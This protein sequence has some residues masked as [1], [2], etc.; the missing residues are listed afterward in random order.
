MLPSA[1][2]FREGKK[3]RANIIFLAHWGNIDVFMA[4]TKRSAEQG[5]TSA[6]FPIEFGAA[7]DLRHR[8]TLQGIKKS[9]RFVCAMKQKSGAVQPALG[10]MAMEQFQSEVGTLAT[11]RELAVVTKITRNS[12]FFLLELWRTSADLMP[13]SRLL[14]LCV[15]PTRIL[16]RCVSWLFSFFCCCI[17][18][19]SLSIGGYSAEKAE[20]QGSLYIM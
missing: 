16:A 20:Q 13:L 2:P 10:H 11:Q 3:K 7:C 9:V 18:Y 14:P 8:P 6:E 12:L 19:F 15:H 1:S 17:L 4:A 5:K